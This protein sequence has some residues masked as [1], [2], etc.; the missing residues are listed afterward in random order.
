MVGPDLHP[1][2]LRGGERA[3]GVLRSG[4]GDLAESPY[5]HRP[6]RYG[7]KACSPMMHRQGVDA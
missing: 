6:I 7:K 1:L 2:D 4:V 5:V 3:A